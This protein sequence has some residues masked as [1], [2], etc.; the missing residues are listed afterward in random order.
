MG[1]VNLWVSF[2]AFNIFLSMAVFVF[3]MIR[4]WRRGEQAAA[5][6]WR[7]KTLEWQVASPPPVQNFDEI[8]TVSAGPYEYGGGIGAPAEGRAAP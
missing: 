3:N 4:S 5:N 8:P 7:A 2:A 6:P 1:G